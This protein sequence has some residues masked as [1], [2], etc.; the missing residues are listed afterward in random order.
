MIGA[1]VSCDLASGQCARAMRCDGRK[2]GGGGAR[3]AS[4]AAKDFAAGG[5]ARQRGVT[6]EIRLEARLDAGGRRFRHGGISR[7]NVTPNGRGANGFGKR[8]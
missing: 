8:S 3:F 4:A 2:E 6:G 7:R 5:P 1:D